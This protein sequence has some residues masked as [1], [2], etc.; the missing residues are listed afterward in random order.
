MGIYDSPENSFEAAEQKPKKRE[1]DA[2]T[3]ASGQV[4]DSSHSNSPE[5]D[6]KTKK[7]EREDRRNALKSPKV[8]LAIRLSVITALALAILFYLAVSQVEQ[9]VQNNFGRPQ[10]VLDNIGTTAPPL[11]QLYTDYFEP[12]QTLARFVLLGSTSVCLGALL[13]F[14]R[15]VWPSV[16][17]IQVVSSYFLYFFFFSMP[18]AL[19]FVTVTE[20]SLYNY[21]LVQDACFRG[22]TSTF[23]LTDDVAALVP[24][25]ASDVDFGF[26]DELTDQ[27]ATRLSKLTGSLYLNVT[28]ISEF[29]AK[30]LAKHSGSIRLYGL[31][32]IDLKVAK[33]LA[34]FEGKY[35]RL[36]LLWQPDKSI[37]EAL[38]R[39]SRISTYD[40]VNWVEFTKD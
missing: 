40:D 2:R 37:L 14:R 27:A 16:I 39:N 23:V 17:G 34:K 9:V 13:V 25:G 31:R 1:P 10:D 32:S 15:S 26:A 22:T 33:A 19:G 24:P 21:M 30:E 4:I 20:N 5:S 8:H 11:T 38:Q 6:E 29:Q 7:R 12:F 28:K 35:L 3:T 18:F 36:S